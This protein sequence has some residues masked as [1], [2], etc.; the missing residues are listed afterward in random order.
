MGLISR[1][2]SRTYRKTKMAAAAYLQTLNFS[3]QSAAESLERIQGYH[4][5]RLW[6]QLTLELRTFVTNERVQP[7]LLDFYTNFIKDIEA[8]IN[9]LQLVEMMIH[10]IKRVGSM[11]DAIEKLN[12]INEIISSDKTAS[13]LIKI[14]KSKI[15][16]ENNPDEE[17]LRTVRDA[18]KAMAPELE[19]EDGVSP[20]HSRFYELAAHY[21]SNQGDHEMFYRNAL[22]FLGCGEENYDQNDDNIGFKLCLAALL[23]T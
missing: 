2:S 17:K 16:L 9:P 13:R 4:A 1:V 3:D 22:R 15:M 7:K 19:K 14:I 10:V 18:I 21:Y 20:V 6:H 11:D 23:A 8:R 5:N 12:A